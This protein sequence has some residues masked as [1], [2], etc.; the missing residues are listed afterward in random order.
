MKNFVFTM[1]KSLYVFISWT[2]LVGGACSDS[3]NDPV[4][5]LPDTVETEFPSFVKGVDLSYVNQVEDHNGAYYENGQKR[6]PYEIL[7][8][9]GANLVRL[10]LWHNPNWVESIYGKNSIL[11][12]GFDDVKRSIQRAKKAGMVVNLD[13]HYS[14]IWADPESQD[15]PQA[16][17]SITDIKVLSD[18]VYNYTYSVLNRLFEDDLL[19]EM[20]QIGNETNPGMMISKKNSSFPNLEVYNGQWMN[21]GKIVNAGIKAV[22]DI[23]A[24][25][26]RKTVVALHVADP[27]NLEWWFDDAMNKGSITDFD[28]M[29]FSFYHN[30]HTTISFDDLPDLVAR[31]TSRFNKKMMVLETAYPF[32]K[33]NNDNYGNIF[34]NQPSVP[35]FPYTIQ[36]QYDFMKELNQKMAEAGAIGVIYWEPAWITSDMRDLW[37]KGS[38]WENCALFDFNGNITEA[39]NYLSEEY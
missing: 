19:P 6:D 5:I 30:W 8:Q 34:Y 24:K 21:F 14:D 11:Y 35:G 38:S 7:R 23:D 13:F 10:R 25:T 32:T 36:G 4:P 16:W 18:S 28:V 17:K 2:F 22:R 39:A 1:R 33:E 37:N 27:K 12:S 29:G 31:L 15:V 9:K 3:K 26:G 20:V